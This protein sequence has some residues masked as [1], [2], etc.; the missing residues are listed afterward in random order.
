MPRMRASAMASLMRASY[1]ALLHGQGSGTVV[2]GRPADSACARSNCA[3]TACIATRPKASFSVVSSP[4]TSTSPCCLSTCSAHAL[5]LPLLQA[6]SARG[7]TAPPR[8]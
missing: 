7:F 8:P 2:S 3:R 5:S 6:K 4:T 1:S